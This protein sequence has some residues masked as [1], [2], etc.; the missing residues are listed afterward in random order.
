LINGMDEWLDYAIE[1]GGKSA[2]KWSQKIHYKLVSADGLDK[3]MGAKKDM[4]LIDTRSED[5]FKNA[6]KNYWENI[7]NIQGA[8]NVPAAGIT[9]AA[10]LP[11]SKDKAIILYGF[12]NQDAIYVAAEELIKQGYTNVSVLR[13]G[14]W[15]L[16]WSSHNIKG[17]EGLN[18]WVVNVPEQNL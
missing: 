13:S 17:K 11:S 2:V 7:G 1:T 16:R 18:K 14:I 12:N 10:Q 4:V 8:V 5:E 6:S 3:M 9:N 15:N